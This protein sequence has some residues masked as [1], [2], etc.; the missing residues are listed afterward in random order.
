MITQQD[1]YPPFALRMRCAGLELNVINDDDLLEI[2][3]ISAAEIFVDPTCSWVF[4]W[5]T[6][7]APQRY[8]STAAFHWSMR[9]SHTPEKWTLP[10]VVRRGAEIVGK[11]DLRKTGPTTGDT[12]SFVLAQH[13]GKGYATL[14]RH[15]V[16]T[17]AFTELTMTTATTD[18]HPDNL[19]SA[20]VSEKL[21]YKDRSL[22]IDD[23]L[24]SPR[25]DVEISGI[26]PLLLNFLG[27]EGLGAT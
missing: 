12:G 5:A 3:A 6:V 16:V 25:P 22:L 18:W 27:V 11:I 17:L 4:D 9:A 14:M 23:Y 15:A 24:A 7:P 13:Q 21:G 10:F 1:L 26:S 19:A 20:R 2:A 8:R